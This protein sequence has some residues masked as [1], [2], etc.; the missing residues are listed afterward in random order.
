MQSFRSAV[1]RYIAVGGS[2]R[3]PFDG[4]QGLA[5]RVTPLVMIISESV[6]STSSASADSFTAHRLLG[7]EILTHACTSVIEFNPIARTILTKALE[8]VLQKDSR[9][10][11][12]RKAPGSLVLE[13]LAEVGDIRSAVGSLEFM[14]IR[15]DQDVDWGGMVHHAKSKKR[16]RDAPTMTATEKESLEMVTQRE[17]SL[18]LFHAVA[19]VVYNKREGTN[20]VDDVHETIVPPPDHLS[21]HARP[22]RS[23]VH[24]EDLIDETGADT[25]TFIS[26]LHENYLL[27]CNGTSIDDCLGCVEGCIEALSESDLLCPNWSGGLSRGGLGGGVGRGTFQ[28]A[29]TDTLRQDE[30]SFQ[31]SV[32]GILFA[33][34]SPVKR[35]KFPSTPATS[36]S[37]P[38]W[39]GNKRSG[40]S[41]RGDAFKMYY[42]ASLRLWRRSEEIEGLV[43]LWA[44]RLLNGDLSASISAASQSKGG[45]SS[46]ASLTSPRK[47]GSIESWKDR[48]SN[49]GE[50]VKSAPAG[51]I[52]KT[53]TRSESNHPLYISLGSISR[54]EML[55]DRLPYM[56]LLQ[57]RQQQRQIGGNVRHGVLAAATSRQR[58]LEKMTSF[59][60]FDQSTVGLEEGAADDD[61]A[62]VDG[63]PVGTSPARRPRPRPPKSASSER[64]GS[65]FAPSSVDEKGVENLVLS[66]DDIEDDDS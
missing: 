28:G 26:A 49:T 29:G 20:P 42:P 19:K 1:L 16:G 51:T 22:Q 24:V 54:I 33:L 2:G 18:G 32:R 56:A 66:D 36:T 35:L 30:I 63:G 55:L 65:A 11:G 40:S 12:R 31:I 25:S 10:S 57:R 47:S 14:C 52:A 43:D 8:L 46:S 38:S 13:R 60:G 6:L 50:P 41:G 21:H 39:D 37:A 15:G 27:S 64:D 59:T 5:E 62:D 34:P 53:D 58:E 9:T 23:Q 45:S 17:A 44:M 4:T 7:P 48:N 3:S 61:D